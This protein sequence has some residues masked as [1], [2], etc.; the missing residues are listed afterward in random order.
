MADRDHRDDRKDDETL[1][2]PL[3][4]AGTPVTPDAPEHLRASDTDADVRRRRARAGL[5][6]DLDPTHASGMGD[7]NVEH[8]GATGIDMGA[9]GDDTQI[10][11]RGTKK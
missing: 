7:V 8:K 1:E 5:G 2:S 9:G 10:S 11:D 6:P 4:I 3:G